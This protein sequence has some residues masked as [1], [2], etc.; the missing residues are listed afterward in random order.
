MID[1]ARD[2]HFRVHFGDGTRLEILHAAGAAKASVILVCVDNTKACSRI[3]ELLKAEFPS[4]PVLAR[5]NDRRHALELVRLGVDYQVRETFE[6]AFRLGQRALAAMGATADEI[7]SY[8]SGIRERDQAR[9]D[10][11]LAG[12]EIA[13]LGLF[14][15]R[16]E[17]A[18]IDIAPRIAQRSLEPENGERG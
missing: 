7:A 18:A 14:T 4:I 5:V 6:S 16:A 11:E 2:H 3:V 8:S 10:L 9:F 15:G 1:I 12:T 17:E 13:P